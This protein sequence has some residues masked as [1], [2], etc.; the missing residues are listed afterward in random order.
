M[1]TGLHFSFV[2]K[3]IP[4]RALTSFGHIVSKPK[5]GYVCIV[6]GES[7]KLFIRNALTT[8]IYTTGGVSYYLFIRQKVHY[9]L[10]P[11]PLE[12]ANRK[13]V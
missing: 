8:T 7:R 6:T 9:C 4:E 1:E 12:A 10:S 3:Q 2:T 11:F 13:Y 5:D